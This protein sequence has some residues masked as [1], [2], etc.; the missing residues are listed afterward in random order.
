MSRRVLDIYIE[1]DLF[2]NRSE[3]FAKWLFGWFYLWRMQPKCVEVE[4]VEMN[5]EDWEKWYEELIWVG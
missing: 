2:D 4:C 1:F 3:H 5:I